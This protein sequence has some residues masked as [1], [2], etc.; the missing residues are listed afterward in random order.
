MADPYGQPPSAAGPFPGGSDPLSYH[1]HARAAV[2]AAAAAASASHIS[3]PG[4][5]PRLSDSEFSDVDEMGMPKGHSGLD[6]YPT[7]RR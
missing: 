3:P 2:A 6:F 1:P 5:M 7:G 4:S